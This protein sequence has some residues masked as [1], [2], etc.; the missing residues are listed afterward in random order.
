MSSPPY[1][2]DERVLRFACDVVA[3][4]RTIDWEPGVNKIVEQ[5][6]DAAGS[7]GAN[8]HESSAGSPGREFIRFTMIAL[9]EARESHFWLR[10]CR[11]SKIGDQQLCVRPAGEVDQI[12]RILGSIVVNAKANLPKE[13]KRGRKPR[14]SEVMKDK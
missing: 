4:V 11:E 10:V 8:R 6:V 3:F 12:K 5:L 14:A 2:I 7:T 9:R 1:D 13:A